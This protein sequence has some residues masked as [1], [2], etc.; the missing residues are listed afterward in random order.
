[1]F[2]I[3]Q[4]QIPFWI[5]T[6]WIPDVFLTRTTP[7]SYLINNSCALFDFS[8]FLHIYLTSSSLKTILETARH[9]NCEDLFS[10]AGD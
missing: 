9:S 3:D 6:A 2:I 10:S 4:N 8:K 7:F 1:M 5:Y